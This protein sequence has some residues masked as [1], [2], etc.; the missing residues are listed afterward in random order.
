MWSR[1][2]SLDLPGIALLRSRKPPTKHLD[3]CTETAGC[4]GSILGVGHFTV[5]PDL[6]VEGL[7]SL[8]QSNGDVSE[9][10]S[11]IRTIVVPHGIAGVPRRSPIKTRKRTPWNPQTA[12][13]DVVV[14]AGQIVVHKRVRM[15]NLEHRSHDFQARSL[16]SADFSGGERQQR[17]YALAAAK[18]SVTHR[19]MQTRGGYVRGQGGSKAFFD[20]GARSA[21]PICKIS[22]DD[23]RPRT[24]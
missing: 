18:H 16:R 6:I 20:R 21:R 3:P 17:A 19:F 8:P 22:V 24:V 23:C 15:N 1:H 10:W 5:P 12:A 11:T 14:H 4:S 7:D 9:S 2:A 13:Q